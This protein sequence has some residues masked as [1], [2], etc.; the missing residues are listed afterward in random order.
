M[1]KIDDTYLGNPLLKGG[2]IRIEFTED[3]LKEYLR[4]SQDPIYFMES[5][6][7]IVTLDHGLVNITMYDFQK[8]I[9]RAVHNNRFTI[10]KIPRQ[11]GKTTCL[12]GEI[13][14]QVLF[15][16]NYKVAILANKLKTAT[17]IM[18]RV[19][20]VYENLPKWMQQGVIE[21]NKTS[22]T[23]ENGSKIICSSTSSS[24]VR[25]S[26]F[27][28]L[29]L[30]EFAFVPEEIAEDFFASVYPTITAG[31]TTKTVVVSTPNGLNL[32]YKMWQNAKSGKSNF[33][34]VEAH[35]WQV[36]GRDENFKNETIKNTSERHWN[37]EYC[38]EF[39]G[40]Q[41]TLVKA[42]KIA[43]LTF[44]EPILRTVDGLTVYESPVGGRIYMMMVD[45][46]RA[47]EQDYNAFTV[48]DTTEMPYKVVA[49][50]RN[51]QIPVAI[52]PNVI[53]SVA[54]KYNE[55]YVLI[56]INDIGQQVAD[57][58]QN[59]L[60]YEN[61]LEVTIQGKKSQKVGVAFGGARTNN[62]VKSSAQTKKA[63]CLALKEMIE[64]DKLV[65]NDFDII[66]EISTFVAKGS[67]YEASAGYHDDLISTLVTF[68]WLSTQA[69]F[70]ELTNIDVRKRLYEEKLRKLENDLMP[71]GYINNGEEE[72][73]SARLLAREGDINNKK[74][75]IDQENNSWL[76][77]TEETF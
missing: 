42:S 14:Q 27:N 68:G 48:I 46:S 28:F 54:T 25:G 65:L 69:Y 72:D 8:E 45:T 40:S 63:G 62:G 47:I 60:E 38:C 20:I 13:V 22:I 37:A 30:D 43:S 71:F 2:N 33:V 52:F 32:F 1:R 77:N 26:S 24:A 10:C 76:S 53:F 31:Q 39:L 35:W 58:I 5:Y 21:W 16:P 61:L 19:K 75:Y 34:P 50:Y 7:K 9:V 18:D 74:R 44:A 56:E 15:N 73:E 3:Q 36:P 29:L 17:E 67:S 55:A 57:I 23:L 6:M 12:M 41:D 66:A 70:K 64:G 4:C 11:S 51:N 49:K 59:E